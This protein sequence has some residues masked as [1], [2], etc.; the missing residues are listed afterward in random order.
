MNIASKCSLAEIN[1]R[2]LNY[3]Q[4]KYH[5]KGLRILAFPCNQF[6]GTEPGTSLE[7]AKFHKD[8]GLQYHLFEKVNV[9]GE[10]A[11]PLWKFLKGYQ[12]GTFRN[13]ISWN[14]SKFIVDRNGKPVVMFT[15]TTS[16]MEMEPYLVNYL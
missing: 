11:A 6:D 15:S 13:V 9:N 4:L 12:K 2:Q 3:L 7:I 16:P 14:F 5:S 10:D 8:R 1:Y